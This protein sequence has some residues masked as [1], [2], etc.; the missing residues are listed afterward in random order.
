MP[1]SRPAAS[2]PVAVLRMSASL[3]RHAMTSTPAVAPKQAKFHAPM[4]PWMK[5]YPRVWMLSSMTALIGQ[6]RPKGTMKGYTSGMMIAKMNGEKSLIAASA[7]A[8]QAPMVTPMGP[9]RNAVSGIMISIAR[10]GTKIS[11]RL[12]GMIRWSSFHRAPSPAAMSSG[13]NTCDE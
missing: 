3:A 2:A 1:P 6:C 4:G 13:T 9:I 8:S 12:A 11:C 10:N 7:L 5:S